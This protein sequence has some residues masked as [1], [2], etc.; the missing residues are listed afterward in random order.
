MAVDFAYSI[1]LATQLKAIKESADER[2]EDLKKRWKER[3]K[4]IRSKNK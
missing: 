2:F 4:A 3:I 1:H